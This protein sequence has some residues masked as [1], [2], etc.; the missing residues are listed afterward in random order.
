MIVKSELCI[1]TFVDG[2]DGWAALKEPGIFTASKEDS[3]LDLHLDLDAS[4][5]L[6]NW[7]CLKCPHSSEQ[8]VLLMIQTLLVRKRVGHWTILRA[9]ATP[10]SDSK[11]N[12]IHILVTGIV[13]SVLTAP[14][15]QFYWQY[16]RSEAARRQPS[17]SAAG[18]QRLA[19]QWEI[20]EEKEAEA[21]SYNYIICHQKTSVVV[22]IF[23]WLLLKVTPIKILTIMFWQRLAWRCETWEETDLWRPRGEQ[24]EFETPLSRDIPLWYIYCYILDYRLD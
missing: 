10:V 24:F 20:R 12:P 15:R 8:T 3:N 2:R 7:N 16:K 5:A 11:T 13:S 6:G 14:S 21:L 17:G 23:R 19:W 4:G 22:T 9:V 1:S 18:R